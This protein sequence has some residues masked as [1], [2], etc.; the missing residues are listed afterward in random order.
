MP[1]IPDDLSG[2]S[3]YLEQTALLTRTILE[4]FL[5]HREAD[6]WNH[7]IWRALIAIHSQSLDVS[8]TEAFLRCYEPLSVLIIVIEERL[9]DTAKALESLYREQHKAGSNF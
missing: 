7:D 5:C 2:L 4:Q 3:L 9:I 6:V 1:T 8:K